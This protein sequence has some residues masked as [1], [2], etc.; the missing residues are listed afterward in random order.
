M[1]CVS[2]LGHWYNIKPN[3]SF[4]HRA[5]TGSIGLFQHDITDAANKVIKELHQQADG[6]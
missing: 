2:L 3:T 1:P 6:A 5:W 4:D